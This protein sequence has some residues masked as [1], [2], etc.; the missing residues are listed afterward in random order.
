VRDD[1]EAALAADVPGVTFAGEHAERIPGHSLT[2]LE[3]LNGHALVALLDGRGVAA[4]AGPACA[5]AV[6]S[7]SPALTAMG[8]TPDAARGA[9]RLS[10]GALSEDD[11]GGLAAAAVLAC[12]ELLWRANAVV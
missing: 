10:F 7:A 8:I 9:L 4:A 3:G 6:S 5:S 11:H 1:Y 12:A 2:L